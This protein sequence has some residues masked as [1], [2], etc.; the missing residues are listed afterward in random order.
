MCVLDVNTCSICYLL[1]LAMWQVSMLPVSTATLPPPITS[2]PSPSPDLRL[3]CGH[4][5]LAVA[6]RPRESR[7]YPHAPRHTCCTDVLR[8]AAKLVISNKFQVWCMM[9]STWRY[10]SYKICSSLYW[11][12][13][14][15]EFYSANFPLT[16]ENLMILGMKMYISVD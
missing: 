11:S 4:P 16:L 12:K 1:D 10:G 2:Q 15:H 9:H 14:L 3:L 6:V 8:V 7:A 5:L 13:I